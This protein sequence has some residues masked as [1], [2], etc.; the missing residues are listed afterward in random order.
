MNRRNF[1]KGTVGAAVAVAL[2]RSLIEPVEADPVRLTIM[3]TDQNRRPVTDYFTDSNAW[4]IKTEPPGGLKYF[5]RSKVQ[6]D[7]NTENLRYKHTERYS[8]PYDGDGVS[9]NST[10]HPGSLDTYACECTP[11][12]WMPSCS[13]FRPD[14]DA[15]LCHNCGGYIADTRIEDF[16]GKKRWM[17]EQLDRASLQRHYVVGTDVGSGVDATVIAEH[18][19]DGTIGIIHHELSEM[20]LEQMLVEI[21]KFEAKHGK[22]FTIRPTHFWPKLE[23]APRARAWWEL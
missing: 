5:K 16:A 22:P 13:R 15:R 1:L 21:K 18:R 14:L 3:G 19:P 23:K 11:M 4:F 9:L 17:D 8:R 7:F 2:G 10:S 12:D 6:G 20:S